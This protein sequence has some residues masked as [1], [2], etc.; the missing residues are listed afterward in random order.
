VGDKGIV[1]CDSYKSVRID[2]KIPFLVFQFANNNGGQQRVHGFRDFFQRIAY[3]TYPYNEG[4][5]TTVTYPN[6]RLIYNYE[7][8]SWAIFIDSYT[9]LGS[10]QPLSGRTWAN[11]NIPWEECNFPWINQ[12]KSVL[13]VAG[14]NQ[15]GFVAILD[16]QLNNDP[17]LSIRAITGG[18]TQLI[19]N[20]PNHNLDPDTIITISGIPTGTPFASD[21]NS[22][23]NDL[24]NVFQIDIIDTDNFYLYQYDPSTQQFTIPVILGAASYVGGGQ[25]SVRDNFIIQSKKFSFLDQGE[26]IQLG[27]V[28]LLTASTK[29]GEISLYILLNYNDSEPVNLSPQNI[30]AITGSPDGFFNVAVP[31]NNNNSGNI[32]GSKYMQRIFCPVRGNF[33][34]LVWTFSNAQMNGIEQQQNVEIDAQV[35][36][37]RKA[38]RLTNF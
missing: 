33:I 3:W 19:I 5:E 26:N 1:S 15:Q 35:L 18:A 28:D 4:Q 17:M 2:A 32:S 13:K 30:S 16:Q 36:W 6:R 7:N 21:L 22:P 31:T 14:I 11:T 34:T 10:F 9:C 23:K 8:D 37:V 25:I 29:N 24:P 12:F 27:H 20:C 38:G